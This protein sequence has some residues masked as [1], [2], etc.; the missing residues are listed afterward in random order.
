MSFQNSSSIVTNSCE[1]RTRSTISERVNVV[2]DNVQRL[3]S[4]SP[5]AARTNIR[6]ARHLQVPPGRV[7]SE[8]IKSYEGARDLGAKPKEARNMTLPPSRR[9]LAENSFAPRCRQRCLSSFSSSKHAAHIYSPLPVSNSSPKHF[10]DSSCK[11][12]Y[13]AYEYSAS[14]AAGQLHEHPAHI[15]KPTLELFS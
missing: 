6:I 10:N 13:E 7:S 5:Q 12:H 9:R 8:V 2:K 15:A 11:D 1:Q 4:S 14:E 3:P